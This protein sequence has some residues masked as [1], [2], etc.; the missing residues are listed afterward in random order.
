M[1]KLLTL[2]LNDGDKTFPTK[3]LD[4]FNLVC[5]L[6]AS[7]ID[8]MGLTD[9]NLER[10]KIFSTMRALLATLINVPAETAGSYL[11]QHISHGGALDDVMEA[12]TGAM[13]DAGFG[14]APAEEVEAPKAKRG[15]K[16][17]K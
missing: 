9:G 1:T 2:K 6:E 15:R 16:A 4:F 7:G 12:F 5:E 8:V 14:N 10:T 3:D 17:T 13:E 11:S